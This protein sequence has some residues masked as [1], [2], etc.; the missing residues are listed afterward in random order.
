ME[1]VVF[2]EE[3]GEVEEVVLMRRW[4]RL[5]EEVEEVVGSPECVCAFP[6]A[7]GDDGSS[8]IS[9]LDRPLGA[10]RP[11]RGKMIPMDSQPAN[12]CEYC[13]TCRNYPTQHA[14]RLHTYPKNYPTQHAPRLHT[15][16]KNYTTQHA[17]R[18]RWRVLQS[19]TVCCV[20]Q[21]W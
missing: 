1:E 8:S 10:R 20:L 3:V 5:V 11:T 17:P 18:L 16:P 12:T 13:T 4:R 15:Y 9:T 19:L 2:H 6:G 14:P 7:D 21:R